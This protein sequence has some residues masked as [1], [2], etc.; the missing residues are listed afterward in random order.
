MIVVDAS[1]V[2]DALSGHPGTDMLRARLASEELHAPTLLDHEVLSA[3]R[4]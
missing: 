3:L 1:A 2:V 4:G